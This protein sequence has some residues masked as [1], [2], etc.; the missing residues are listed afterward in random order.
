MFQ[1]KKEDFL[2]SVFT[3]AEWGDT[4]YHLCSQTEKEN[5]PYNP[6]LI[7]GR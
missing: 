7:L 3:H 1:N 4:H 5:F 2:Q 6:N